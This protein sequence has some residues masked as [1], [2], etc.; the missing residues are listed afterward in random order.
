[1]LRLLSV[2]HAQ[3]S[4][5][6]L[7]PSSLIPPS[8]NCPFLGPSA[9]ASCTVTVFAQR[10]ARQLLLFSDT[11][12]N[13]YRVNPIALNRKNGIVGHIKTEDSGKGARCKEMWLKWELGKEIDWIIET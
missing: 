10:E 1:M 2:L 4:F 8:S 13:A 5:H 3:A 11:S 12:T 6:I 7:P 9:K